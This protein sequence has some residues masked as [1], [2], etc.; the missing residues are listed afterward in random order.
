MKKW[1]L[2]VNVILLSGL[3]LVGCGGDDGGK[4]DGESSNADS[5]T[6]EVS[7][8]ADFCGDCGQTKGSDSCC[9]ADGEKC[10]S[11]GFHKGATL[12]CKLN[13]ADVAGKVL[14]GKCGDAKGSEK[15]CKEDAE[16]CGKCGLNKGTPLCCKLKA[17]EE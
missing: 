8:V 7:Q 1:F 2:Q 11:C 10:E 12:C 13:Q 6:T 15:C 5:N 4:T 16:A 14:C 3:L 17:K 9:A